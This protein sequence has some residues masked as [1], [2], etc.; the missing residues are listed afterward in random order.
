[1]P[2]LRAPLHYIRALIVREDPVAD[3]DEEIQFHIDSRAALLAA[4]G[5]SPQD[6]LRTARR[7]FGN[8]QHI[9]EE[10][11]MMNFRRK[12]ASDRAEWLSSLWQD[13]RF[14]VRS[15]RKNPAFTIIVVVSIV[16][17]IGATTAL[18]SVVNRVVLNTLP[19]PGADRLV[20]I[21]TTNRE[22]GV[23][24]GD[25]SFPDFLDFREQNQSFEAMSVM[26]PWDGIG[27]DHEGNPFKEAG[28]TVSWNAFDMLRTP[29]FLGRTF[30][31]DDAKPGSPPLSILAHSVWTTYFNSDPDIIGRSITI[32]GGYSLTVIGVMPPGFEFPRGR[33]SWYVNI[34]DPTWVPRRLR[35]LG[36]IGRLK[37]GVSFEAAE[38]DLQLIASRLEAQYPNANRGIGVTMMWYRDVVLG[39]LGSQLWILLAAA[40]VLLLI[41]CVNVA[42]LLLARGAARN[43][44]IALRVALGAGRWRITRQ[45]LTESMVMAG[46]GAIGG[47]GLAAGAVRIA[48]TLTPV[49]LDLV[50]LSA[51]NGP[52]LLF[53]IGTTVIT[54]VLF[55]LLPSLQLGNPDLRGV[56]TDGGTSTTAGMSSGRLRNALVATQLGLAVVLV[57]GAGLLVRSFSNLTKADPGLNPDQMIT[58]ELTVP[59]ETYHEYSDWGDFWTRLLEKIEA[60]P[61]VRSAAAISSLPFGVQHDARL[62]V[63]VDGRPPPEPGD[64]PHVFFRQVT[65]AF[66]RTMGIPMVAGR[67]FEWTDRRGGKRVAVIN[68]AAAKMFFPDEDPIGERFTLFKGNAGNVGQYTDPEL[69]PEPTAEIIGVVSNVKFANLFETPDPSIFFVHDQSPFRRMTVVARTSAEPLSFTRSMRE[70]LAS[71]DGLIPLGRT[72]TMSRMVAGSFA[73]QRFAMSLLAAFAGM[74]LVLASIGVYG[75]VSYGVEQRRTELAVRMALG[76]DPQ[77][78]VGLVMRHGGLLAA[79]GVGSGLVGAWVGGRVLSSQLFGVT[80]SDPVTFVIVASIL[81]L[82]ALGAS[83][84]P[85]VRATR[86][87][88]AVA[89]KPQ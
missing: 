6:A 43:R 38:S 66:F 20:Q 58:F 24:R 76:A 13:V 31:A 86:I 35:F 37:E 27:L 69:E 34:E 78:V 62:P 12:R 4:D 57:V 28:T 19:W 11:R 60:V 10:C 18:F 8:V 89:L 25:F 3:V 56:L 83:F 52:V 80:A 54:G 22:A 15:L 42:N 68:E 55:G 51:I 59:M 46:L 50:Q 88:P 36:V 79:F 30:T 9:R 74:A 2:R 48:R 64:E 81:S 1:M 53:A 61:G 82:I 75:V 14:G 26:W 85:A 16:L 29:P 73:G 77:K 5:M 71:M 87:E 23:E 21:W 49:E 44:E 40:G 17:G 7:R 72:E 41:A 63:F 39:D 65:P 47:V 32:E 45:L 67:E 84:I 70:Q 33:L